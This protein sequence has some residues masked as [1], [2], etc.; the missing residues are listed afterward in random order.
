MI[1]NAKLVTLDNFVVGI[2]VGLEEGEEGG[3]GVVRRARQP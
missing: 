3:G 2:L 1:K